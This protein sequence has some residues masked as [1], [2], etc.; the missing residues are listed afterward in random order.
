MRGPS[1]LLPIPGFEPPGTLPSGSTFGCVF[2]VQRGPGGVG[3]FGGVF[4]DVF[5]EGS[6]PP[7]K[8]PVLFLA[9]NL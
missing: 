8:T 6:D 1:R 4:Q 7:W 5:P 3:G 9:Q 2:T